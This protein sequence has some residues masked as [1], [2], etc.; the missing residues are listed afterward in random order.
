MFRIVLLL[1]V[2]LDPTSKLKFKF[3]F[4]QVLYLMQLPWWLLSMRIVSAQQY[5]HSI[6]YLLT[7]GVAAHW[8]RAPVLLLSN[9]SILLA[10]LPLHHDSD[11]V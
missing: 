5:H 2:N 3:K 1:I 8:S 11:K 7:N 4:P 9:W 10:P 6:Y